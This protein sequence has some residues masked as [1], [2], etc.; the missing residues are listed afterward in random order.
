MRLKTTI[1]KK[2]EYIFKTPDFFKICV[3]ESL[4]EHPSEHFLIQL[5][6]H[7]DSFADMKKKIFI[8]KPELENHLY[9]MYYIGKCGYIWIVFV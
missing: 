7:F 2:I 4:D 6:P 5:I 1:S 8:R 9:K 3:R